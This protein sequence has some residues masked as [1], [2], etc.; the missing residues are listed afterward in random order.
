MT[1]SGSFRRGVI[2]LILALPLSRPC[3]AE[4][5]NDGD[6]AALQAEIKKSFQ[7]SVTP[8]VKTYCVSCHGN[9]KSKAGVN[10]E[11]ALKYPGNPGFSKHWKNAITNV[12]AHDM[13]PDDADKQPTE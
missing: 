11:S 3:K 1:M 6:S 10:F 2:A 12:K 5:V 4:P 7:G 13:P 8:F 9:R